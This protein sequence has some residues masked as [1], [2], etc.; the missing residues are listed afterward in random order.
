MAQHLPDIRQVD[1]A[2]KT[3]LIRADLNVPMKGGVITDTTRIERFA[4]T[5]RDIVSGGGRAVVM[6]HLGRPDAEPNPLYSTR[7]IAA[8]L[9]NAL[10]CDVKFVSDCVGDAAER[11]TANLQPG[12]VVVLENLRFHRGE[13][14][15]SRNFGVRLSVNGDIYV[16]DAFSCAHRAHAS[17]HAIASL[18]PSFAGPSLLSEVNALETVLEN[19]NRPVA[20]L[21]GGAKVSTK[22][23]VLKHLVTKVDHLI[24]GGGMANTF[25]AALGRPVGTSLCE[26]D[27]VG[28]AL[29]IL[30]EAEVSGCEIILP[31]DVVVAEALQPDAPNW[32]VSADGIPA[33]MMAL[34]AGEVSCS[35]IEETL[36]SCRTLL[37]NGPLGAFETPP[38]HMA[39]Q[40]IARTAADL[41]QAGSLVT[42]AGGGDTVAALNAAG[43]ADRF[44]YVSTAG[45][46]F[47]EWLEGK[48]LPGI[49]VLKQKTLEE[50]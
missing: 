28:S 15:N 34:D 38:F 41:T 4:P 39:T 49:D 30:G 16:N 23:E 12:S 40:S 18:M 20:A 44:T 14:E 10:G 27:A 21:V 25:L 32:T 29:E 3:V 2:G 33:T 7:P 24:I 9:G 8:A 31:K 48:D 47:L 42:V 37:W 46:A 13:G 6:T 11:G 50:A 5:V 36:K 17:T 43:V 22:I 1:V 26:I 45:G 19:P 35:K